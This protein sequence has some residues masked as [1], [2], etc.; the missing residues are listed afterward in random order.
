MRS[1]F[2]TKISENSLWRSSSSVRGKILFLGAVNHSKPWQEAE[3][4]AESP[5]AWRM[6]EPCL[7]PERPF[8]R[9]EV[10]WTLHCAG[11]EPS[12][13]SLINAPLSSAKQP[14]GSAPPIERASLVPLP[15]ATSWRKHPS[16]R[17]TEP[18]QG[19]F[20]QAPRMRFHLISS[21]CVFLR[22]G[23]LAVPSLLLC[24]LPAMLS[25]C[26]CFVPSIQRPAL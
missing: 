2:G 22:S 9:R 5:E 20:P 12:H 15:L 1:G 10:G 6:S 21:G 23:R 13:D 4:P 26:F 7:V 14:S 17:G 18:E 24:A 16:Q 11:C 3:D 19:S 8:P 25:P